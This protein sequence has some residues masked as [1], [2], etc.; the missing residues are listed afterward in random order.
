MKN[1]SGHLFE[2]E[3]ELIPVCRVAALTC[4]CEQTIR[5][6]INAGRL[7]GRKIGRRWFV[8]RLL[9]EEYFLVGHDYEQG[10]DV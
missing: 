10:T 6:E 9:L 8:P 4:L 3:P 2:N 5:T 1:T 7:P